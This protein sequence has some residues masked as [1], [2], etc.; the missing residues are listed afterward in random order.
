MTMTPSLS[1][2][3]RIAAG[4]A[5]IFGALTIAS[6][7]TVL[8]GGEAARAAAG[9]I[10]PVVLW[11]NFLSGFAYVAA[12]IG[13][14]LRRPWA[15]RLS[16]AIAVAIAAVFA[17]FALQVAQGAPYELRTAAAMTLRLTVWTL[18]AWLAVRSAPQ[19]SGPA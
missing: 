2:P 3:L 7:G 14:A 19:G 11:F 8:F 5:V 18:I 6:G 15:T 1:W 9:R 12:G 17:L 10:V 13:I 4:V 16:I